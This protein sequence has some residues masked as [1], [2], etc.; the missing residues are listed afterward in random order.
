MER[1]LSLSLSLTQPAQKAEQL[2][3]A[4][5]LLSTALT[6]ITELDRLLEGL[7]LQASFH[8]PPDHLALAHHHLAFS[9]SRHRYAPLQLWKAVD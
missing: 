7:V 4:A 9:V 1:S 2:W 3:P 8:L 5:Q 6:C